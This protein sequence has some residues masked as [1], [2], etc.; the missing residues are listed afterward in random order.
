MSSPVATSLTKKLRKIH[1]YLTVKGQRVNDF[2][3]ANP[4]KVV[5]MTIK[6]LATASGVS[7][8]SVVRFVQRLGYSGFHRFLHDLRDV[9]DTEVSFLDRVDLSYAKDK[10]MDR[11]QQV[12]FEGIENLKHFY[13]NIA[14]EDIITLVDLI[15]EYPEILVVGSRLSYAPAYFMGWCLSKLRHGIHILQGSD[16]TSLDWLVNSSFRSLVIIF[17]TTRYPNELLRLGKTA[18]RQNK[19]LAVIADSSL[20]PLLSF[21]DHSVVA[22]SKNIPL[23]G[24]ITIFNSLIRVVTLE[25][26]KRSNISLHQFQSQ[27]EQVYLENDIFFNLSSNVEPS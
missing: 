10:S 23:F 26:A 3:L 7:E 21:A 13:K 6:E 27:L 22:A 5:F 16:S 9:V 17:S 19:D 20:C 2:I 11:L 25:L 18:K 1:P 14:L 8:A 4:K 24:D 15:E 12:V